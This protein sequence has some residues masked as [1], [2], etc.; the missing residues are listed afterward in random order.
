MGAVRTESAEAAPGVQAHVVSPEEAVRLLSTDAAFGLSSA[1]AE[2]RLARIGP[3]ALPEARGR[4]L[5]AAL[6]GQFANFL[7]ILLLAAVVL[8]AAIGEYVD[9]GTIA[10]VVALSAVLGLAQEWRAERSLRALRRLMAPAAR[11]V[12]DGR[13]RE[14][15][16]ASLVPGDVVLLDVGHY[17]PA[18]LRLLEVVGLSVNESAL[19]GESRPVRK[20]SA[21]VF[22]GETPVA[23]RRNCAFAGTM[24]TYGRGRGAVTATGGGT[25]VGRIAALIAA[26]EEGETPLQRRMSGLGRWLGL[27][28]VVV[29]AVVF[30]VG[31]ATGGDLLDM[32][33][34]AVSLA[35]AAVPEGLPA[36]VTISLALGTQRMAGRHALIRRLAAVETLGSA[37]VIAADKTGTL[38]RG[39]M[40]VEH[41]YTG[42][43]ESLIEVT[44][45]GY[46]P[47]GDFRRQGISIDPALDPQLRLLLSAGVLCNDARLQGEGGRWT[48]VGDTTEGALVVAA[49][50]AGLSWEDLEGAQARQ[51]EVPFT[52]ERA[53]MTTVHQWGDRKIAYMKGAPDVVL[54]LCSSRRVKDDV[55]GLTDEDRSRVRAAND[56]LASRGLRL[57]AVAYRWM[58]PETP[59]ADVEH[60]MVFVGLF[61]MRDPPRP[62][63]RD[64]VAACRRA[65]IIPLMIT[66][67]HAATALAIARDLGMTDG[68]G[69]V[70][71]GPDVDRLNDG[72]LIE[73]TRRV[74]VYA[75]ISPEQKT[76]IV[77]A[78]KDDGHIVAVTGDGV[79]DAPALQRA[80]IG[81]AM[82]ITGTDVAKEAADMV[83]TD[84]NFASIVAAVEEGRRI[85]DNIRNF[86]VLLLGANVGE[87]LLIFGG[88]VAGL[89]LP[90]LAAQIL[91]VNL[92]TDSLPAAALAVERGDPDAMRRGPRA[93][94][95][96]ILTRGIAWLVVV[97]GILLGVGALAV[98][99]VWLKGF[100]S[101]EETAR[102]AALATVVVCELLEAHASRSL[103]RTIGELG[104]FGNPALWGA[105]LVSFGALAAV[106]YVP[107]LQDAFRVEAL[108]PG[109]WLA[110]AA[111]GGFRLLVIEGL[112]VGPWRLRSE[113]GR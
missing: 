89:P 101:S 27:A 50:K 54:P 18:D 81:V 73:A 41:I 68:D 13:V 98:F 24:V 65:G 94:G 91:L 44:G 78:L 5:L 49:Q 52:S 109:E 22:P 85:F 84:D 88:V 69:E 93:P 4:T 60:D 99:A 100:D 31:A 47:R 87:I 112:K 33:L 6:A 34:T 76:R 14:L 104:P 86:V 63:A 66:G 62:E 32:L 113:E 10:A 57:L 82:G 61:A 43:G 56:E 11:A 26:H 3:N 46:E 21:P 15:P 74:R 97:R 107:A 23:D 36:V 51:D 16:A 58:A 55:T 35:V 59:A 30:V 17:V 110:A 29:S 105:T 38:T 72:Q 28:A 42:P 48:V 102:S 25:E 70:L 37:T 75:R 71:V 96:S 95:E 2:A 8:A 1:E 92:V 77:Q 106:L 9:A 108:G 80:D 19:T 83:I 20:E 45:A 12:R 53:R 79:N 40:T 64:A 7:I 90:L 67:D 39:E 103:H 111:V